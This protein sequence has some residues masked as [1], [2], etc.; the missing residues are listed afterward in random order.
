MATPL[1]IFGTQQF[2]WIFP[3]LFVLVLVYAILAWT[4]M[5]SEKKGI[6]GM[7]AFIAALSI[8]LIY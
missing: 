4:P 5:F 8:T 6:A 2:S 3:F 1:D 7:L